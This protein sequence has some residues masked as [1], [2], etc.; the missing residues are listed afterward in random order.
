MVEVALALGIISFCL[1]AIIGLLAQGLN[2]NRESREAAA[3]SRCLEQIA[4]SIRG[5][6]QSGTIWTAGGAYSDL[7]W[8]LAGSPVN[9]TFFNINLAGTPSPSG[10]EPRMTARVELKP[11]ADTFSTGSAFVSVAWPASATWNQGLTNWNNAQGSVSS[12]IIFLPQP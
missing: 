1:I 10:T 2:V 7:S 6:T 8:S 11:P 3:A 5:A 4:A 12:W 9:Q